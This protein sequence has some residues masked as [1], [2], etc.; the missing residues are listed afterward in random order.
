MA[1]L[2]VEQLRGQIISGELKDGDLLP[3][4]AELGEQFAVSRPTLREALRILESESLIT[5]TRGAHGGT[6]VVAP[7]ERMVSRYVARYLEFGRVPMSD[8][9]EAMMAIEL[10]AVEK[11]ARGAGREDVEALSRQLAAERDT[12]N[13]VDAFSAGTDFHRLLV[14]RAGNRTLAAM[15][16]MIEEII[17]ASGTQIGMAYQSRINAETQR[18]HQ[19][20]AR[21][22]TLISDGAVEEASTL[23]AKHLRTKIR[24]LQGLESTNGHEAKRERSS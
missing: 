23:W 8:V 20:H 11:L 9:H 6:R 18:F 15:H 16:R 14:D 2:I 12:D 1:A 4:E 13:W 24:V 22:V 3:T 7:S 17:I 5:I 19:V 10:P 21:I